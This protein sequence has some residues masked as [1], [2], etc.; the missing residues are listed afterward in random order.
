MFAGCLG[1][2]KIRLKAC[3]SAST[4][5]CRPQARFKMN[6]CRLYIEP[7]VTFLAVFENLHINALGSYG[8]FIDFSVSD[9]DL[10]DFAAHKSY[11]QH[12]DRFYTSLNIAT[13]DLGA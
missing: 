12:T 8:G 11:W 1:E 2:I 5:R 4:Q 6:A 7:V 9:F 13:F 10:P 3:G